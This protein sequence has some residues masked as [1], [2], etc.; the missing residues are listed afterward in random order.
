MKTV[1][2]AV[3]M[4]FVSASAVAGGYDAGVYQQ[5]G[6]QVM[7]QGTARTMTVMAVRAVKM[8]VQRN[9][10]SNVQTY[11]ITAAG[12]A[13]GGIAGNSVGNGNGRL[14]AS[15]LGGL[16]GGVGSNMLADAINNRTVDGQELTL[17]D[18]TT[19]QVVVVVQGGN[20]RFADGQE[21]LAIQM[22]GTYRVTAAP[23]YAVSQ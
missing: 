1:I 21:V 14:L 17:L 19:R 15:V 9:S 8:D 11:A 20:E 3:V 22:G 23:R 18:T 6:G 10:G 5:Q 13:I 16:I 2:F 12:A 4:L 7:Q